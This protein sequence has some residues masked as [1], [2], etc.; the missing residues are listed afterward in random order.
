MGIRTPQGVIDDRNVL[1]LIV[2]ALMSHFADIE[3][4]F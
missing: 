2:F 3:G 1:P 4:I